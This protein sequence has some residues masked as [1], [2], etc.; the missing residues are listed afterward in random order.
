[1]TIE[2][3]QKYKAMSTLNINIGAVSKKCWQK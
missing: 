2:Y 1:M 3:A